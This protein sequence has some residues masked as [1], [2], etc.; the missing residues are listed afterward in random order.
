MDAGDER[1]AK[2]RQK[3]LELERLEAEKRAQEGAQEDEDEGL[4]GDEEEMPVVVASETGEEIANPFMQ[5]E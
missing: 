4:F 2:I 5:E 3:M 1:R